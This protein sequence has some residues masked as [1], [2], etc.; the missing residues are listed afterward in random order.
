VYYLIFSLLQ[1]SIIEY[2]VVVRK[3]YL[4]EFCWTSSFDV[5]LALSAKL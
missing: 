5:G 2:Y 4:L 1:N 3:G